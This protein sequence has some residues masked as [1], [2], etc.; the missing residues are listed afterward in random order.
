MDRG[1]P[2]KLEL[3]RLRWHA[4][5]VKPAPL[6]YTQLSVE[7][8]KILAEDLFTRI[9]LDRAQTKPYD[10]FMDVLGD[11]GVACPHPQHR[12][13]YSGTVLSDYPLVQHRWYL[14]QCCGMSCINEDQVGASRMREAR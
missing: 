2:T 1:T 12:R 7:E 6:R 8:R 13:A 9:Y 14:C 11:W 4:S 10:V 3:H 5:D